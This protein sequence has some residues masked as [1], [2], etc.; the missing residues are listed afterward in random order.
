MAISNISRYV[1]K[2][3]Y[4]QIVSKCRIYLVFSDFQ[5]ITATSFVSQ[6]KLRLILHISLGLK[7]KELQTTIIINLQALKLTAYFVSTYEKLYHFCLYLQIFH[8]YSISYA[9]FVY[10]KHKFTNYLECLLDPD[11]PS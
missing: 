8:Q 2:E 3:I 4:K 9:H 5:D 6:V 10:V 11:R 1:D 7:F